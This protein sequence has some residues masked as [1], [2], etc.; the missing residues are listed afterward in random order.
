MIAGF[1]IFGF[2]FRVLGFGFRAYCSSRVWGLWFEVLSVCHTTI[3]RD[4]GGMLGL[5]SWQDR[6]RFCWGLPGL[7]STILKP[8]PQLKVV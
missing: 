4:S 1:K 2:G 7:C 8:K 3:I 5:G 6:S